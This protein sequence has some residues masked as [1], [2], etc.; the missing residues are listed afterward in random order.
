MDREWECEYCHVRCLTCEECTS[1]ELDKHFEEVQDVM[2]TRMQSLVRG[3]RARAEINRRTSLCVTCGCRDFLVKGHVHHDGAQYLGTSTVTETKQSVIV[4]RSTRI[5]TFAASVFGDIDTGKSGLVAKKKVREYFKLHPEAKARIAAPN[6]GWKGFFSGMKEG[7]Y[8]VDGFSKAVSS[9]YVDDKTT[10]DEETKVIETTLVDTTTTSYFYCDNCWADRVE[11]ERR[12][13][14]ALRVQCWFRRYL[15]R[16]RMRQVLADTVQRYWSKVMPAEQPL[17]I[18]PEPSRQELWEGQPQGVYSAGE[19]DSAQEKMHALREARVMRLAK[20]RAYL[21]EERREREEADRVR[22]AK[23]EAQREA[24]MIR[25]AE[26]RRIKQQ[27]RMEH[28]AT[29]IQNRYRVFVARR[30]CDELRENQAATRLQALYRG[31]KCREG[32]V[33]C[34][35]CG[36]LI[37][38]GEINDV[39]DGTT[40]YSMIRH[41]VPKGNHSE[42]LN[43]MA[44][45]KSVFE[46]I[47]ADESKTVTRKQVRAFFASHPIERA[48]IVGDGFAWKDFFTG[49]AKGANSAWEGDDFQSA[50]LRVYHDELT[51]TRGDEDEFQ[52]LRV[53]FSALPG[54]RR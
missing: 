34:P 21:A 4:S 23:D 1:H 11:T 35:R 13:D 9:V 33:V 46:F 37:E 27:R 17:F 45:G 53:E 32:I 38:G 14:A 19:D 20:E 22:L 31:F 12:N 24:H 2:V 51:C 25:D 7:R 43:G 39:D 26:M 8:D 50:I 40:T 36:D 5:N 29:T 10:V 30:R 18:Q 44:F 28:A 16:G 54:H 48:H 3:I 15:A 52:R 49:L 6:F 47:D 42:K 41:E